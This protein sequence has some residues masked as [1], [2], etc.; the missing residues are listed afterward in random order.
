MVAATLRPETMYGQTNCWLSPD[1]DYVA[2]QTS[3]QEIFISTYR[4]ALNMSYQA[5]T[6]V[7]G[8]IEV[9]AKL[10][11][12]VTVGYVAIFFTLDD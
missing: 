6:P 8:Q 7:E 9:L 10:K 12:Q 1:M 3:N 2:F 4:A 5:M 11:G